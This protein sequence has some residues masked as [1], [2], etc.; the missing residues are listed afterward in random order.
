MQMISRIGLKTAAAAQRGAE[1][2]SQCSCVCRCHHTHCLGNHT[3]PAGRTSEVFVTKTAAGRGPPGPGPDTLSHMSSIRATG[4][5]ISEAVASDSTAAARSDQ[6][7]TFK[8]RDVTEA[9]MTAGKH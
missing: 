7:L 3:E 5:F 8:R 9:W 6:S 1:G 2:V 4:S